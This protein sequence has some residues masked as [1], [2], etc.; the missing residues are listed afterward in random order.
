[1][2]GNHPEA[3]AGAPTCLACCSQFPGPMRNLCHPDLVMGSLEGP[4]LW[5]LERP[6]H[7]QQ[8]MQLVATLFNC[9]FGLGTLI[10][11]FAKG[12]SADPH[13][14]AVLQTLLIVWLVL[15]M[16]QF[17]LLAPLLHMQLGR[18]VGDNL[19][20]M[21]IVYIL[22]RLSLTALFA[23]LTW[24]GH[25]EL[26]PLLGSRRILLLIFTIAMGLHSL[27]AVVQAMI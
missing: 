27:L 8:G 18:G 5:D 23:I 17:G 1:M 14:D 2:R 19:H 13:D 22:S 24:L 9:T 21:Q 15:E 26:F 3:T 6:D 12:G 10:F 20:V 16:A 25:T 11:A 4:S 7:Q